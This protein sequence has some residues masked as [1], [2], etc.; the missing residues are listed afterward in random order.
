MTV[1]I[2]EPFSGG[3]H[4]K[5]IAL[6]LPTLEQLRTRGLI[7]RIIVVTSTTHRESAAFADRLA[8]FTASVDFDFVEGN[9][10]CESGD[11]VT[12]ILLEAIRRHQPDFL[13]STSANNGALTLAL[14]TFLG[15]SFKAR[16]ITS[17]GI[18]HNGF[19]TPV[20]RASDR[21]RDGIHRFS[22]R[23]A[24]WSEI[25][26]VNPVLF[27]HVRLQGSWTRERLKMLSDPVARPSGDFSN[28]RR[29]LN[30]PL[31]GC[32]VGM[33]GQSDGRKA[34]PELLAAFREARLGP[35][36]RLLIAGT[37]Y[38]P[39]REHLTQK[40]SE[41]LRDGRVLLIDRYLHPHELQAANAACDIIAV[42]YYT[43]ELSSNLLAATAARR[44]VIAS[45]VGYTGMMID[46]FH[47]GW[48]CDVSNHAAF[49]ETIRKAVAEAP[50]YAPSE[51]ADRLLQFHDPQNFVNTLL[52]SLYE[53]L[54]IPPPEV[55]SWEWASGG[56]A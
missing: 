44:P 47:L 32:I 6:L 17:V 14:R 18:I 34:L 42:T 4:T 49:T 39:Y 46:T 28:A 5:Y 26:I 48:S 38:D 40:Y 30:L 33:I 20:T 27:E 41:E 2:F 19:S 29:E 37:L 24:P 52:R 31:E 3:H 10:R 55:K 9:F 15:R 22:R 16:G 35:D 7:D 43:D 51:A 53:R 11:K 1:A 56:V 45:R 23:Y 36:H 8:P 54:A 12:R 21:L 25:H 13:I 50:G